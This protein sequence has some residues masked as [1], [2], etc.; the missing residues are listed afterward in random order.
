MLARLRKIKPRM[1]S[2][3]KRWWEREV[4]EER[5]LVLLAQML[6][7]A[8]E[9]SGRKEGPE[10]WEFAAFS[11]YGEDGILQFLVKATGIRDDERTFVEFGVGDYRE[12]NTRLLV[13][14]DGWRGLVL[15]CDRDAVSRIRSSEIAWRYSVRAVNA[16][17]TKETINETLRETGGERARGVLSIDID[18]NDYWVWREIVSPRPVIVVVE[19]NS[20]FG[21]KRPVSVPYDSA[22]RRFRAH[23]SG[24]Y[25]GCSLAALESLGKEKG[26]ALICSNSAGNNAFFVREDRL[27]ELRTRTAREAWR[28]PAFCDVRDEKG[29]LIWLPI[30]ERIRM[31]ESLPVVDVETGETVRVGELWS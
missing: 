1:V 18:G 8:L 9:R 11:Q 6:E 20:L 21:Y 30:E 13:L 19:Y 27:G 17:I 7:C 31:I 4:A 24:L 23:H 15:D 28:R 5:G 29:Q 22:F 12:A 14:K 10:S 2:R 3:A 26:Y 16:W 25:W